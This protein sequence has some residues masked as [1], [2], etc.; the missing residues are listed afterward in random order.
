MPQRMMERKKKCLEIYNIIYPTDI[1]Q[2]FRSKV[3]NFNIFHGYL[4]YEKL[5]KYLRALKVSINIDVC[6]KCLLQQNRYLKNQN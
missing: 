2:I 4:I 5:P 6:A 3:T 1:Y